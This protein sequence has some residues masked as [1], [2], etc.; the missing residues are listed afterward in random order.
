M[1]QHAEHSITIVREIAA[2]ASE[3]Y[4][5]WTD[6]AIMRRWMADEVDADVRVGGSYRHR[7]EAGEAGT[8]VHRGAYLA[9]EPDHRIVQTFI[10]ESEDAQ[11]EEASSAAFHN[12]RL[13]ITLRPIAAA[14]TELTFRDVWEGDPLDAEGSAAVHTAWGE[15]LDQLAAIFPAPA[16]PLDDGRTPGAP[17]VIARVHRFFPYPATRVFDAWLNPQQARRWLFATPAGEMVRAEIDP[18]VGGRFVF[19]E[20]REG[21]DVEHTGEYLE[22]ERP[23]RLVFTFS[24]TG[25]SGAADVVRID[26]AEHPDGCELFLKHEMAAEYAE[27]LERTEQGW[28]S[29]LNGLAASLAS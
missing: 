18:R 23:H 24:V 14:R 4:A 17:P 7:I 26:I 10:P 6:P 2:S 1:T 15:W 22:L 8:F 11:T 25:A 12:E 19:T 13:E 28:T 29:I 5:A 27:Y 3:V 9:L 21:E 20:R 16:T